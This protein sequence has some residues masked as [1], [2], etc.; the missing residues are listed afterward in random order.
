MTIRDGRSPLQPGWVQQSIL[1]L[2]NPATELVI[3]NL[4][5]VFNYMIKN[6]IYR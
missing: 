3:N 2:N 4:G 5:I 6:K 1:G